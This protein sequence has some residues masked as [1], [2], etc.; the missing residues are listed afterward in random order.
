MDGLDFQEWLSNELKKRK[1]TETKLARL[2]RVSKPAISHYVR[3]LRSPSILMVNDILNV[4][5]MKLIIVE[6]DGAKNEG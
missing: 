5:G 6:K 4:L 3:G 1:M 2:T